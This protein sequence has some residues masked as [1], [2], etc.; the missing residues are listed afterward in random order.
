M[1]LITPIAYKTGGGSI[2][3]TTKVGNLYIG[4]TPQDYGVVG[5]NNGV[6]FYST[7][8]QNLGYVIAHEDSLGGHNGKPNNVPAYLGFWRSE[9]L[10]ENSFV[11]LVNSLFTQTFT[12]GT[13]ALSYLTL[14]NYW[15]SYVDTYRYDPVTFL[16]WPVSSAGYTLYNGGFTNP[17][18]GF[19]NSPISLPTIFETNNQASSNLYL[20]TNGYFTL[21]VGDGGIRN[22]PN[23]AN[24]ATMAANPSDNW[25]QPGL[26]NTDGDVQ[27]WYYKT[28]NDGGGKYYVKNLVYGGTY[29]ATTT[30]TSYVINFYRDG[31]Y[32]WLE[33]R[34][35][36]ND[37]GNAGPYNIID[38]SQGAST[39]S[40]VWRGDLNGQNWVYMGVGTVQP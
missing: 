26:T 27:N 10:T 16:S 17:D 4:T 20:S 32:Q 22:S 24:P 28:G 2:P 39:T 29:N 19:S 36:S 15:T 12:G 13:E 18:D 21:G 9:F 25:L 35:K 6:V 38:V 34:T 5:A 30:P 14:N 37:R 11:E 31:T 3:G 1:A 23:N 7:P 33:T 40:R 8:D